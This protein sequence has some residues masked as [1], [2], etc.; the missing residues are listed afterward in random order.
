MSE[1]ILSSVCYLQVEPKFSDW[2]DK[3]HS[4]RVVR[5]TQSRPKNSNGFPIIKI[6]LKISTDLLSPFLKELKIKKE[7]LIE[8]IAY[9]EEEAGSDE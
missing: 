8:P 6:R 7:Q 1:E 9:A 4:F 2:S 5:M 3:P